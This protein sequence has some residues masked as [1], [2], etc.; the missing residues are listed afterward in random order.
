LNPFE[1]IYFNLPFMDLLPPIGWNISAL[2]IT[3]IM[4]I[5]SIKHSIKIFN[6]LK[7]NKIFIIALTSVSSL[8][9]YI[10]FMDL[11]PILCSSTVVMALKGQD[12]IPHVLEFLFQRFVVI[13]PTSFT[14]MI[15]GACFSFIYLKLNLN[16]K[17]LLIVGSFNFFRQ[18]WMLLNYGSYNIRLLE[19]SVRI[20][21]FWILY[22]PGWIIWALGYWRFIKVGG[23]KN[24][25]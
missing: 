24:E 18:M 4:F 21:L 22:L 14:L 5:Y 15:F 12:P 3:L 11:V 13:L 2:T 7:W 8:I 19:D 23:L 25:G 9:F 6:P 17:W 10:C 16:L 20:P 1:W